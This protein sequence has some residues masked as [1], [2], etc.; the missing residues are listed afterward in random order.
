MAFAHGGFLQGVQ[1]GFLQSHGAILRD[2]NLHGDFVCLQEPDAVNFLAENV[3]IFTNLLDGA[4]A[5]LHPDFLGY[6]SYNLVTVQ[7]HHGLAAMTDFLPT[8]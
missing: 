5:E 2:A 1:K 3:G 8:C 7:E 6:T 4:L